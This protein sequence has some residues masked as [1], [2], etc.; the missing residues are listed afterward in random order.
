METPKLNAFELSSINNPNIFFFRGMI[1][2]TIL[3]ILISLDNN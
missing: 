1:E 2:A 3:T